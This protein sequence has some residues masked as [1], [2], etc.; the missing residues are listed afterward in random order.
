MF[1]KT[2][3]KFTAQVD[4]GASAGNVKL[5]KLK[6]WKAQANAFTWI[7]SADSSTA[8]PPPPDAPPTPTRVKRKTNEVYMTVEFNFKIGEDFIINV[9]ITGEKINVR[10]NT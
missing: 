2:K 9:P 3:C 10:H 8:P 1:A 7:I 6:I 5:G 4:G